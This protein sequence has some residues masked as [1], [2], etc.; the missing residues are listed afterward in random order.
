MRAFHSV[1]LLAVPMLYSGELIGVIDVSEYGDSKRIF[2]QE[3]QI[4]LS[5]LAAHAAGIVA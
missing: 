4:L 1:P 2:T 5:L 3:M